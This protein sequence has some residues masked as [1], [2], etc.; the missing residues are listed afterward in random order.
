MV[1][2]AQLE[3]FT[4]T[5]VTS[6]PITRP[7]RAKRRSMSKVEFVHATPRTNNVNAPIQEMMVRLLE[8]CEGKKLGSHP[9]PMARVRHRAILYKTSCGGP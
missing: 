4:V 7:Q 1:S 6:R 5:S 3:I 9:F 2:G 8:F